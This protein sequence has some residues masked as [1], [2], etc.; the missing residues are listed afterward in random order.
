MSM[1]SKRRVV[2]EV[3]SVTRQFPVNTVSFD[4]GI[5]PDDAKDQYFMPKDMWEDMGR[6]MRITL[7]VEPGDALN[8]EES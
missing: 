2:M 3:S 7:S 4:C 6:P 5:D 1:L 8:K